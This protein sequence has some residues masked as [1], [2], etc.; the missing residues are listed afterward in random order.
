MEIIHDHIKRGYSAAVGP[1][2]RMGPE[3][4][5]WG[6]CG[7]S[8]SKILERFMNERTEMKGSERAFTGYLLETL[9]PSDSWFSNLASH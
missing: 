7:G 8:F 1:K 3:L 2:S 9:A 5:R 4:N 6:G